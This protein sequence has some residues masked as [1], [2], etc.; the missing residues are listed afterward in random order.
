MDPDEYASA[1]LLVTTGCG[2]SCSL[3]V[4]LGSVL[5]AIYALHPARPNPAA[6]ST[7]LRFD[8]PEPAR[9]RLVVYDALGREV[10]RLADGALPAG[11]HTARLY[12]ER[13]PAGVYLVRFEADGPK[14][15]FQSTERLTLV[16]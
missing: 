9:V 3:D 14:G 8:L 12:G 1:T 6:T 5:P 16:R 7:A 2:G 13:L 15:P 10:A 11:A 4:P